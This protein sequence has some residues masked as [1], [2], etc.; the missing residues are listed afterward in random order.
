MVPWQR[1]EAM[2]TCS[3]VSSFFQAGTD[4]TV[5]DDSRFY[6]L[7]ATQRQALSEAFYIHRLVHPCNTAGQK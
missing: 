6:F 7:K 1:R 4:G 2:G 3:A 5:D